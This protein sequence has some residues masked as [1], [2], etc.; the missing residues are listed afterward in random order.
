MIQF[1]WKKPKRT[2]A[3]PRADPVGLWLTGTDAHDL[4]CP[5]GYTPLSQNEDVRACVH[6]IADLISTMTIRLME[7][8]EQGDRRIK[9]E[10]SRRVDIYPSPTMTR[11]NFIY[12]LVTDL[13]ITGNA[14]VFPVVNGDGLLQEL[15]LWR[16]EAYSFQQTADGYIV[17]HGAAAFQPDEV[18]HFVL[19][20]DDRYPFRGNG[21]TPLVRGAVENIVQASATKKAFLQSK[22]KPSLIISVAA[23]TEE[24][25]DAEARH[26]ILGSYT[27]TTEIGEPWLIPAG[28]LSVTQV[29]PLTLND[30]AI[31]DSL[32][33]DKKAVAAAFGLPPFL[34]GV[35]DFN[36]EAYN[37]FISAVIMPIAQGIQQELTRKLLYSD[38]L[39]FTFNPESLLQYGELTGMVTQLVNMGIMSRNE[40]RAKFGYTPVDGLDGYHT[41]ENYVPVEKL[42]DQKKL[43]GNDHEN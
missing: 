43:K 27:R 1:P 31:Q 14:V 4:L 17:R 19:M 10:L 33:L 18:L 8:T 11:K 28:E 38:R 40:A 6:R 32:T 36:R 39:Y 21:F 7:N 30:L 12:R 29:K 42:G 37:T 16:P 41:L 20:P 9:N 25:R 5:S 26:T 13:C 24:L 22:W 15:R 2:R 3:A 34:L 35:G 23:D